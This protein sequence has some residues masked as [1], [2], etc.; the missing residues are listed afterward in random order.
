[1]YAIAHE[2]F[3]EFGDRRLRLS[4]ATVVGPPLGTEIGVDA[5]ERNVGTVLEICLHIFT[6]RGADHPVRDLSA[7]VIMK[8][9]NGVDLCA[10]LGN[11]PDPVVAQ[12]PGA[13]FQ[14]V[15]EAVVGESFAGS[16]GVVAPHLGILAIHT[17]DRNFILD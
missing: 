12:V 14:V 1:A 4:P 8:E 10:R 16:G 11:A 5:D 17:E 2:R 3:P 13:K 9:R 15:S 7:N 6:G